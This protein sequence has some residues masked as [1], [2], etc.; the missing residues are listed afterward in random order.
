MC[1]RDAAE[2]I[3]GWD[4]GDGPPIQDQLNEFRLLVASREG[5][6]S[7]P[8]R[9]TG[10]IQRVELAN[11]F[12]EVSSTAVRTAIAQSDDWRRWV[13]EPVAAEIE[14]RGLYRTAG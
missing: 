7:P 11:P 3:V 5:E 14:R 6:Y 8:E 13:T 10:R 2:R 1:G 12:D 4:Y 9:Y